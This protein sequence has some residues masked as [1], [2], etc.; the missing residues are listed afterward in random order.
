MT[1][2]RGMVF[3]LI[4][5]VLILSALTLFLY[6]QYE[7][8]QA[9][10]VSE[11]LLDGVQKVIHEKKGTT[12]SQTEILDPK[13]PITEIDGYGYVGYI[14]IPDL[15]LKL[16]VMSEWDYNRLKMAPCRQSGSSRTDDLVIVAHNYEKHFG[17]ISK[18]EV[19]DSVLFT[20]MDGIE[21]TYEVADVDTLKPTEVEKVQNSDYDLVLYTCTYDSKT[22]VTV[23][24]NRL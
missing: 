20:D 15:D 3:V 17:H 10:Q 18:L 22:R 7:N 4:G 13:L 19:G 2:K 11:N 24:C 21:N 14:S 1:K 16:P 12:S 8:K 23:F 5:T 9:G 6:N